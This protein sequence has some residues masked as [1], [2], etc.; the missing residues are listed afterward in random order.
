MEEKKITEKESMAIISEMINRSNA[1]RYISDGNFLLMWGYLTVAVTAAVWALI[2]LTN[3]PAF[4]YLYFLVWIIGAAASKSMM[5]RRRNA[6]GAT[7][8]ADR[9]CAGIWSVVGYCF[10]AATILSV[11][12]LLFAGENCWLSLMLISLL[13]VGFAEVAQGLVVRQNTLLFGGG[14]GILA[15]LLFLC[16]TIGNFSRLTPDFVYPTFIV[17]FACMMIIPGH[18]LNNKS[19]RDERS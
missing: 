7:T 2:A 10:L 5:R 3:H 8:Y 11:G 6:T 13:L 18:I 9:L 15:G 4:N 19:K 1:T 14:V 17:A 16:V 12:F